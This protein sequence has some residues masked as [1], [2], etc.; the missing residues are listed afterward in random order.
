[1]EAER[2]ETKQK[3]QFKNTHFPCAFILKGIQIHTDVNSFIQV[4]MH[5][6]RAILPWYRYA[7]ACTFSVLSPGFSF[8]FHFQRFSTAETIFLNRNIDFKTAAVPV[9]NKP[10]E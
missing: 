1:M 4:H 3:N 7:P 6:S 2:L 5:T 8:S 10:E 9:E